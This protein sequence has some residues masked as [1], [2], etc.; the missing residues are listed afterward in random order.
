MKNIPVF[1]L[2]SSIPLGTTNCHLYH[3][4][5]NNPVCYIDPNGEISYAV[6]TG[7]HRWEY[8]YSSSIFLDLGRAG[9]NFGIDFFPPLVGAALKYGNI[10]Y[11][12]LVGREIL[13]EYK[14]W[15]DN[16]VSGLGEYFTISSYLEILGGLGERII[17]NSN[18]ITDFL[19]TE[20]KV[21]GALSM[22]LDAVSI[23]LVFSHKEEIELDQVI[24]ILV[25]S[26]LTSH[27]KK[28]LENKYKYARGKIQELICD[29]AV[30]YLSDWK[31]TV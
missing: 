17:K 23:G 2:Q 5:G 28:A 9:I 4:A 6:E 10:G 24:G 7:K 18:E 16:L 21:F 22:G 1:S 19:K 20:G 27:S 15:V 14:D 26:E 11:G 31:G 25:G 29:G 8:D 13:N 3:Y 30:S 12:K